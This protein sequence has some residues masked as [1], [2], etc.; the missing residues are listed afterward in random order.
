[1]DISQVHFEFA[2]AAY[3]KCIQTVLHLYY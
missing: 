1:L 3:Y 2:G